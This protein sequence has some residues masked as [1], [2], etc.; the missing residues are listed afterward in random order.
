MRPLDPTDP[1]T[2]IR[3]KTMDYFY[4]QIRRGLTNKEIFADAS[5]RALPPFNENDLNGLRLQ[6]KAYE[7]K[8]PEKMA[9]IRARLKVP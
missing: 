5:R 7:Q 2:K 3:C 1:Q 8:L 4:A 6:F 9:K